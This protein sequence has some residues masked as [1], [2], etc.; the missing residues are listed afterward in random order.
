MSVALYMLAMAVFPLWWSS[1]SEEFG[2]RSI[3]LISFIF[4]IVFSVLCAVSVNMP[5]LIVFRCLTGGASASVQ[6]VGAGTLSDIWE[7]VERGRAMGMF[8]LGPLLGPILAPL[9]GG[10]LSESLGWKAC[11]YFLAVFGL[12]IWVMVF[13][14][15]PETL[16]KRNIDL[17]APAMQS[18]QRMSTRESAKMQTKQAATKTKR[19]LLDPLKVLL[20]LRFPPVLITVLVAAIA[21]GA[22]F[23]SNISI[24]HNFSAPPYNYSQIIVGVLYLPPGVGYFLA[25]FFGGKWLDKIMAREARKANR[26]DEDGKLIYLPEDRMRENMWLANTIYPAGLLLFG[27]TLNF[28]IFWFVPSIGAFFFGVA[29]MLVFVSNAVSLFRTQSKVS[30]ADRCSPPQP[31]CSPSLS[32]R[33]AQPV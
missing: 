28:G 20:M 24:Q 7:P 22:L 15:L 25:A 33:G 29:S 8:Y 30:K 27:W 6:A 4:F 17:P 23:I 1:F 9:I 11:M 19:F 12:V 16:A 3:Y 5:M 32:A 18:L 13:L 21:F 14:F 26:Y 2:R 10:A 31:L